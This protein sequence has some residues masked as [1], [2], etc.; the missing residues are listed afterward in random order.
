MKCPN[1]GS[2]LTIDDGKC[3]F[4]GRANPF[5]VKHRREMKHFTRE[6]NK[7]KATVLTESRRVN[8]WAAKI[9][10]IAILVA[11]NAVLMFFIEEPYGVERFLDR[12]RIE[13]NYS[14]YKEQ[15]D[16]FEKEQNF[17][18]F[19]NYFYIND[20]YNSDRMNE[21]RKVQN[22][23]NY[24]SSVYQYVLQLQTQDSTYDNVENQ[25]EYIAES[26]GYM[27]E[28]YLPN[29]YADE[30]QYK[31]VHRECM[32]AAVEQAEDIIQ[33]F[34]NLTD[35]EIESFETLSDARRVIL[36]EEGM[37]RNE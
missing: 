33:T 15:L 17:I 3:Q 16:K 19:S 36:M 23:C 8:H 32:M 26:I 37:A 13:A 18:A 24:Y 12:R 9:T 27:Y 34:F 1:C 7:T 2:N 5:A 6:F 25:L 29:D 21:Y 14:T 11:L 28:Q 20:L 30:E 10:L 22:V 31:P 35:E 4:C